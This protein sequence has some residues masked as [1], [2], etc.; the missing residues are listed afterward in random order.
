[1]ANSFD[2]GKDFSMRGCK[3]SNSAISGLFCSNKCPQYRPLKSTISSMNLFHIKLTNHCILFNYV[4]D[5]YPSSQ[6]RPLRG[7]L[8]WAIIFHILTVD[9][10]K[11]ASENKTCK[12]ADAMTSKYDLVIKQSA[13]TSFTLCQ[14]CIDEFRMNDCKTVD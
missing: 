14:F 6:R 12:N 5:V 3:D 1:M 13:G 8:S 10:Q 11:T 9:K 2:L 4:N 7:F